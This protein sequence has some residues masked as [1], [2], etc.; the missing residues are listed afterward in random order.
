[1]IE[2][3]ELGAHTPKDYAENIATEGWVNY[4]EDNLFPDH[5]IKLYESS[6]V[7][8]ALCNSISQMIFGE[9]V[10]G[11]EAERLKLNDTIRRAC[12]DLKIQG[13]FFL[14][15]NWNVQRNG[16]KSI[17]HIPFERV[18]CGTMNQKGEIEEFF[19]CLDWT[20]STNEKRKVSAWNPDEAQENPTQIMYCRPFSV[21][22][23]YYPKPDYFGALKYIELDHE[24]SVHHLSNIKNGMMPSFAVNLNNGVPDKHERTQIRKEIENNLQGSENSGRFLINFNHKGQDAPTFEK[25]EV[26][27]ASERYQFLSTECTDKIMIGHRVT[28]PA[29]FGVKTAGQLGQ[30]D[31]L[32]NAQEIF[33]KNVIQ[34]FQRIIK[35]C[36]KTLF[37]QSEKEVSFSKVCCSHEMSDYEGE[38]WIEYLSNVGEVVDLEEW[39]LIESQEVTDPNGE[40]QLQMERHN[41]FKRFADPDAKSEVDTGL[42]KIRYKYSENLSSN[43]RVF[44]KNM[45][46]NAKNGVVYKLEDIESMEGVNAEFA[47]KGSNSYSIWLYKGGAYC[48]HNWIRQVYFRKRKNGRFLP[49]EGLDNDE[50]VNGKPDIPYKDES[51]GWSDAS[52]APKDMPNGGRL[53]FSYVK[54]FIKRIIKG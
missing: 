3:I 19:Y 36:I 4:G 47:P 41:F 31:E 30:S 2:K 37:N 29:L 12:L 34:P 39:D 53:N 21:G 26:N 6:A 5:L 13:G 14:E 10:Q 40:K 28:S 44:C 16:Y 51:R 25:I 33:N 46:A 43:S 15:I 54:Q 35:E 20:D 49:N 27:D 7:H 32:D 23:K 48:H 11:L 1:M 50:L 18:R 22:H 8:G 17:N 9:G 38:Q 52:T 45:V 24:I 42:Y